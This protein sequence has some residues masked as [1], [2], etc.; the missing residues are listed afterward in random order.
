MEEH[1]QPYRFYYITHTPRDNQRQDYL[2][3]FT[4]GIFMYDVIIR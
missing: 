3:T 2:D 1:F 4:N